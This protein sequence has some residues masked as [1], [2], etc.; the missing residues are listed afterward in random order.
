MAFESAETFSPDV[1]NRVSGATGLIQFMPSTA[2][3]L[4]TSTDELA[5]M[6]AEEQL[7]YVAKYFEPYSGRI[8]TVE[9]LYMAILWPSAIG[10]PNDFVLFKSP[11]IAY[12][13]NAGLDQ[14]KDG[15][16]TKTD[17]AGPVIAKLKKGATL[18]G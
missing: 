10:R 17:A 5:R 11:S 1:R 3:R 6:T 2:T 18:A 12:A 4:G 8:G 14:D 16:V 13:Q 7:D 15:A 9:D